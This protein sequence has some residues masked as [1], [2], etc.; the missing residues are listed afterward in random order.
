MCVVGGTFNRLLSASEV[1]FRN[2]VSHFSCC[3]NKQ[4]SSKWF[5]S[6]KKIKLY[7]IENSVSSN[8]IR[9]RVCETA[10]ENNLW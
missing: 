8:S 10:K 7:C 9:K 5:A 4:K 3:T 1:F 2:L 6:E